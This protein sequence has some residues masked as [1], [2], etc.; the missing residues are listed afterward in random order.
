MKPLAR[1]PALLAAL[2]LALPATPVGA[3]DGPQPVP[4]QAA[5]VQPLAVDTL[6][7]RLD[8]LAAQIAATLRRMEVMQ[9][10]I[11]SLTSSVDAHGKS[12]DAL[13]TRASNSE[14]A[15]GMMQKRLEADGQTLRSNTER[16]R[17]LQ[18]N[19]TAAQQD[20]ATLRTQLAQVES[21]LVKHSAWIAKQ[22]VENDT[23]TTTASEALQR[24]LAAGKLAEGKLVY[25]SVLSEEM[26]QFEPYK[27]DLSAAAKEALTA[28]AEEL[29]EENGN[30]YLE[31]QGH[32]DTSG[33]K[34]LNQKISRQRAEA[35]RD[36]L[37]KDCGIPL[38]RMEAVAYGDSKP[39]A[40][41]SS[42]EGRS[43]NRRV[44][45]VVLK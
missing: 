6:T 3:S 36:F 31:I 38:H 15:L 26:T 40:D 5:P 23:A 17:Q 29:K 8:Q 2:I 11:R 44:T 12:I 13:N 1:L 4:A 42:K 24:A 30:I 33:A 28:F 35:V 37:N 25:E 14:V 27:S 9:A 43:K 21:A 20:F 41:N 32:T 16:L 45:V 19:L 34:H 7:P 10:E 22:K 39:I 18:T